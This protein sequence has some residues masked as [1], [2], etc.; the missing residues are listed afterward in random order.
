M[1]RLDFLL[2]DDVI[3]FY[4][5]GFLLADGTFSHYDKQSGLATSLH[6]ELSIH[7][8]PHLEK[9]ASLLE[10]EIKHLKPR[11][12]SYSE[13]TQLVYIGKADKK[14]IPL[15]C[16]KF[17]IK[18]QKT[19]NP[20]D[21]SKYQ[22]SNDQILSLIIGYIDG[23]GCISMISPAPNLKYIIRINTH[24]SWKHN[25]LFINNFI[26]KKYNCLQTNNVNTTKRGFTD[27]SISKQKLLKYMKH[28]IEQ[29]NLPVLSR[30]WDVLTSLDYASINQQQTTYTSKACK[31]VTINNMTFNSISEAARYFNCTNP[32]IK[33]MCKIN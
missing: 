6:A 9:L 33:R 15:I 12:E 29:N 5:M 24:I 18:Q 13:S 20:P 28:F 19:Y 30:K 32:T 4:W 2:S 11:T 22:F 1:A 3:A 23:D 21:F 7:D 14:I 10:V 25:L 16:H 27:L 26:H 17:D 31:P 8:L